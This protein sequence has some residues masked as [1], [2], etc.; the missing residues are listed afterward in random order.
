MA[1]PF[2]LPK[3]VIPPLCTPLTPDRDLDTRSLVRLC[4]F[5][6]DAGV[7]GLFVAGS[8]GEAAYLPDP[9]RRRT[10]ETV[11]GVCAAHVPV[12]AGVI[13]TSTARV[14]D[15]ARAAAASGA[16]AIVATAPFFSPTDVTEFDAHFR[17]IRRAV[18]LPLLAYD[19]PSSVGAKLPAELVAS[20]AADG[21]L[22]AVKDSSGD[23]D[24]MREVRELVEAAEFRL[25]SGSETLA[26]MA[27][28]MGADGL[29]PGLG[30]VDPHGYLRLYHAAVAGDWKQAELEQ[31]RLRRLFTIVRAG[32]PRRM[33]RYS[34]AIGA[35]KEALA[36][37]GVIAHPTT[38]Q[39]MIPLDDTERAT[40]RRQLTDT[41][42]TPA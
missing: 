3:G 31:R 35:F 5:L 2:A 13:D 36:W 41:G 28:L 21:V 34:S 6:L 17:A 39:P 8:T 20:L 42:I 18:D 19:I 11:V 22:A 7:H 16:T 15:Q 23:L 33:G 24:A 14:I 10:L 26:D 37:R 38:S 29:V 1:E 40:V 30:N 27:L 32:D 4:E 25:Y 12:Y 9:V